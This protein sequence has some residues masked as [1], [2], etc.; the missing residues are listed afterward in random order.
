MI[1]VTPPTRTGRRSSIVLVLV[2]IALPALLLWVVTRKIDW[3]SFLELL[4][5]VRAGVIFIAIA[6]ITIQNGLAAL[7]W[8]FVMIRLPGDQLGFGTALRILYV[9]VFVNQALPSSVGGDAVRIWLAH[10][11]GLAL[12]N[13]VK[14]VLLDRILTMFGLFLLVVFALPLMQ[15]VV[16]AAPGFLLFTYTVSAIA[17]G[18]VGLLIFRRIAPHLERYQRLRR[19][20]SF[21]TSISAF[22]LSWRNVIL[23][24]LS[25]M[26]GFSMMTLIVFAFASSLDIALSFVQCLVLCP[27]V[28]FLAALPIS[29]AGWG[30]RETAMVLALGY[31]GLPPE[32]AL[33]LSL[34]LGLTVLAGSTPGLFF[35]ARLIPDRFAGTN[36]DAA[37]R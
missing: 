8:W 5:R 1:S 35:F 17:A 3:P 30:V 21:L 18:F 2:K 15:Q 31:A 10:R 14:S 36:A 6:L 28:F 29:I 26:V 37:S 16:P 23:P 32:P 12:A 9:S 24:T 19:L 34:A 27:A 7:R 20:V 22:L 13:S 33:I 11:G 4:L 25:A